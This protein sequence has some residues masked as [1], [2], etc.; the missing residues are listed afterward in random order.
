VRTQSYHVLLE[1]YR[2]LG[3]SI[4][5]QITGLRPAQQD[6]LKQGFLAIDQ[7][8]EIDSVPLRIKP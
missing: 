2:G 4:K 5:S 3:P 7:D 6:M 1:C 8:R